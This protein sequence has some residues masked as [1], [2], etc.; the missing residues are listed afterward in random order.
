MSRGGRGKA[1][2]A[3]L[4]GA[5]WPEYDP[6]GKVDGKPIGD[7]PP[8]PDLK[9]PCAFTDDEER[10]FK[11]YKTLQ[12][13]V[14]RGPLYTQPTKPN[15]DTSIKTYSED[16]FNKQ[17]GTDRKAD[18][19]PF[20]GVETYSMRYQ[21]P[22]NVIPKLSGRPFIMEFFPAELWSTLE[23]KA[24]DKVRNG[25][26]EAMQRKGTSSGWA[27]AN[28]KDRTQA[29]ND[30]LLELDDD[31]D[32][33]EK[34]KEGVVEDLDSDYSDDDGGDDYNAE[35]YFD[36]GDEEDDGDADDGGGGDY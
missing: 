30:R 1:G 5:D 10:Q 4:R 3:G 11:Y 8:H 34:E 33:E 19:D 36:N 35:Q 29:L 17:Y 12:T 32:E 20:E 14:R 2:R 28:G 18:M 27:G 25:I 23:G 6:E 26:N 13:E 22:K 21:P 31:E 7:Y 15:L 16:Q 9:R 24:G